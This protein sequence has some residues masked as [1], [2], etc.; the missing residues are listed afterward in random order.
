MTGS[1]FPSNPTPINLPPTHTDQPIF[2][3]PDRRRLT[4][5]KCIYWGLMVGRPG[6]M[7]NVGREGTLENGRYGGGSLRQLAANGHPGQRNSRILVHWPSTSGE[8]E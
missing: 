8:V 3:G 1:D 4:N 2:P 5:L 7:G 6:E